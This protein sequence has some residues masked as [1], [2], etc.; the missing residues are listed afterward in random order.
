MQYRRLW[1]FDIFLA[2]VLIIQ[3]IPRHGCNGSY[4]MDLIF[5]KRPI[6]LAIDLIEKWQCQNTLLQEKDATSWIIF[7]VRRGYR[8]DMWCDTTTHWKENNFCVETTFFLMK[9]T[10]KLRAPS[11]AITKTKGESFWLYD[12]N[13]INN[14]VGWPFKEGRVALAYRGKCCFLVVTPPPRD[15]QKYIVHRVTC[16]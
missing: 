11:K 6:Q 14:K 16:Y 1:L 7:T 5:F 2:Q 4:Q 8:C 15:W 12:I 13:V 9:I 3:N 10:I